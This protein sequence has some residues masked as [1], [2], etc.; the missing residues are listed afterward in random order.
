MERRQA[1]VEVGR[2]VERLTSA[3][4]T[5]NARAFAACF[6]HDG[7]W[8]TAFG[9]IARGRT[10]I[11]QQFLSYHRRL[12]GAPDWHYSTMNVSYPRE[13]VAT[14]IG[15]GRMKPPLPAREKKLIASATLVLATSGEWQAVSLHVYYI[16]TPH[17]SWWSRLRALLR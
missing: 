6:S 7:N 12:D 17:R 11:E 5:H 15:E 13:G 16:T 8:V 9:S 4:S 2:L 3:W 14:V 10:A 1:E